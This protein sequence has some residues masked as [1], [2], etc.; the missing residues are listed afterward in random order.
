MSRYIYEGKEE[1]RLKFFL[2]KKKDPKVIIWNQK[3]L[4]GGSGEGFT[5]RNFIVYTFR[6]IL[7]IWFNLED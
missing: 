3:G 7:S 6:L 5:V 4:E 1:R 2:K